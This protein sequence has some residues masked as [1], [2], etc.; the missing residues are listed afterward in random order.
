M[1]SFRPRSFTEYLQIIWRRKLLIFLV[2]ILMLISTFFVIRGLPNV[3]ESRAAIVVTGHK[4]SQQ[5]V[6]ARVAAIHQG[7]L[8]HSF[9][10]DVVERHNLS[11][12]AGVGA[13]S[14]A[15]VA[16]L[17]K[18]ITVETKW[19]DDR[20][21][22]ILIAYRNSNPVAAQAVATDLVSLFGKMNED[23]EKQTAE[24][25]TALNAEIAQ[26]ETRLNEIGQQRTA[27]AIRRMVIGRSA[28]EAN[29]SRSRRE[30]TAS[31]M[32]TLSDKQFAIEQQ[33]AE[34][35]RQIAEQ[36]KLVQSARNDGRANSSYG[37]LLV[38]KAELEAQIN[39][40][41]SQYTEK[42]PKLVQTRNQLAEIN[43]QLAQL[44]SGD[45][46]G[47]PTASAEAREL[48]SLQRELARLNI[49]LGIVQRDIQRQGAGAAVVRPSS[50]AV[51]VAGGYVASSA[52][53][54]QTETEVDRLR[55][56][57]EL[58]LRKQDSLA[59][60]PVAA[61]LGSGLFQVIDKPILPQTPIAPNRSKLKMIA[62]LMALLAGFI[63][64][65]LVEI[66][67]L[68]SIRNDRDV[69]YYLD[70]PVLALIPEINTSSERNRARRLLIARG[71]GSILLAAILI[72]AFFI[73]LDKLDVF[74]ILASK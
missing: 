54:P 23:I 46:T 5:A 15:S 13:I 41:S 51:P 17:R 2:T 37:V 64:A 34:Q 69:E 50:A 55:N 45:Q 53:D 47:A 10:R 1:A 71:I 43:R 4:E 16:R 38:R 12:G 28:S 3:Y 6:A 48:R 32:A 65:A 62:V 66:P 36:E 29:V 57:Y 8:S 27:A 63:A 33:I 73:L 49:E 68:F 40:Y 7:M 52:A 67:R 35:K 44:A 14:D 72:P 26:I 9:L 20:P 61:G 59:L 42:N 21:E 70:V 22:T 74:Q 58:L 30:A 25:A 39:D 11:P 24:E 18:D 19:R 56:R 60:Q 31:S